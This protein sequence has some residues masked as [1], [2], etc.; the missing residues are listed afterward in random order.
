MPESTVPLSSKDVG[1]YAPAWVRRRLA[2]GASAP[3]PGE[4]VPLEGA[5]LFADVSGFTPLAE[6]LAMRGA[7]GAEELSRL[8]NDYFGQ[9]LALV[10]THG[11]DPFKFAGDALLALWPAR[12]GDITTATQRAAACALAIQARL[13]RYDAGGAVTLSLRVAVAQGSACGVQLSDGARWYGVVTGAPL[14]D[15][16]R[17]LARAQPGDAVVSPG[18]WAAILA[19]ASAVP[20][21]QGN[22]RLTHADTP[23]RLAPAEAS[24]SPQTLGWLQGWVPEPA[25]ARLA[26]G[27]GD[28]LGELRQV[29][30]LFAQVGG[31]DHLSAQAPALLQGVMNCTRPIVQRCRGHLHEIGVDDKGV[32][33]VIVFGLPPAGH[34]DGAARGTRAAM[35]LHEALA[36]AGHEG[37][38]G[39]TTGQCFC[40]M[41]GS[42][43]RR[44]M[45]VV[46]DTMNVA[47]RLMEAAQRLP[48]T[49]RVLCDAAT[50]HGA[51][52]RVEFESIWPLA[53]KGKAE[54]VMVARALRG[55]GR[56]ARVTT[57]IVGRRAEREAIAEALRRMAASGEAGTLLIVGEAGMGKSRLV[58][59]LLELA[60]AAGVSTL[61]GGA[62]AIEAG[63]PYFAL[64]RP[65]AAL[66]GVADLTDNEAR[67]A[68]V[69]SRIS[70][71][72]AGRAPLLEAVLPLGLPDTPET[73]QMTG[74]LRANAT[75][76]LLLQ[77]LTEA[78]LRS[79]TCLVLEDAHWLDAA[80]W[81]LVLEASRRVPALQLT[82]T[83]RPHGEPLP[84]ELAALQADPQCR[85]LVLPPLSGEE[86][87]ALVCARLHVA[88]LP[89]EV[90]TMMR[91]RAAG[92]PLFAEELASALLDTGVIE[93]DAGS[94]RMTHGVDLDALVLPDT[95]QEVVTARIDRL[96]PREALAIKVASVIGISFAAE[97]LRDVHP[98]R[99]DVSDL[100]AVLQRLRHA[101]LTVL[102]APDP[103]LAYAFKHVITR[104]VAYNLMLFAQRRQLHQAVAEWYERRYGDERPELFALL[105]HHWARAG[106]VPKAVSCLEKSAIRTFSLGLGH[107]AVEQ[108]LEAA[109]LL[110]VHL[111]TDPTAIRPL[112]G[113][114][115]ARIQELLAGRPPT[116]LLEHWP[117]DDEA[118]GTVIGLLL[119]IMPFAH[120][121]LQAELFALMALRCMSLTL[122]HGNGSAAPVVYAMHSI[123]YRGL[124]GDAATANRFAELALELDARQGRALLGPVSF[125]YTWFNQHWEHPV[126]RALPMSLE[127]AEVAF[128]HGDVL[129]GCFN[130]AAHVVYCAAAGRPLPE[131]IAVAARHLELNGGRVLNAAFHC[132]Q[133]LQFAKALAGR[134][135]APTSLSDAEHDEQRDIA[136]ICATD[137]YNQIGYYFIARLRLHYHF[138][139]HAQALEFAAKA[140]GLLAA[141]AGQTG[142]A[143]LVFFHALALAGRARE[144]PAAE[145]A[146]LL[147]KAQGMQ[148]QLARW[149]DLCEANFAHKALLVAAELARSAGDGVAAQYNAAARSAGA[150]GYVQHEAL[151][152]ELH[153]QAL[154]ER[155]GSDATAWRTAWSSA[156]DAYLRWGAHAK[157]A[158]LDTRQ[159]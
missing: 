98:V 6:R 100:H 81:V 57:D 30:V 58:E 102:E 97:L 148:Q 68:E 150:A 5:V 53:V 67:R 82:I 106:I 35:E 56:A 18:A 85:V 89:A 25:R 65:L 41:V 3:Q 23:P 134:T 40:G 49:P 155:A 51:E 4:C 86:T 133:E 76:E 31:L 139:Q 22:W 95:V 144:L 32:V 91:T 123:I 47:S 66:L 26:A 135:L 110:G 2:E 142:E 121:S 156:R 13:H 143:D 38:I 39:V 92:L 104:E 59:E 137:N 9:L 55:R 145:A 113:A 10:D 93:I 43:V 79:P 64:R 96:A 1:S 118:T 103:K 24:L 111:P 83:T 130:L 17:A 125:I 44:E 50:V 75:R 107:A 70:P 87:L 158:D 146:A 11:G 105:A 48:A 71:A 129:Y 124:T 140:Q 28:W 80:S 62:D 117:L 147:A 90:E 33:L 112:L 37:A 78:A 60:R 99:D 73:A 157:V 141:F 34:E 74:Q 42:D 8:L 116:A 63:T 153:A 46:G 127:A 7:A 109:R 14:N 154:R 72:L 21:G 84:A 36:A 136:S 61:H 94:C 101:D 20:A 132:V 151:A 15:V 131:V 88:T 19:R 27:H 16:V 120:Q 45:A 152:H 77:I 149:A 114:E 108:G 29:T 128:A 52:T 159:A 126:A 119:R 54:P 115:L 12:G 122:L 138:R 69:L